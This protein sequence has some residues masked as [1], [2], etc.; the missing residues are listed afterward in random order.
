VH[1][2]VAKYDARVLEQAVHTI[3]LAGFSK[4]QPDDAP[5]MEFI[6]TYN[7]FAG[8]FGR[9]KGRAD[10]PNIRHRDLLERYDFRNLDEFDVVIVEC[11]ERGLFDEAA[12]KQQAA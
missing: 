11:I 2:I 8:L 10:D 3:A 7:S 12:I 4:F 9:H 1:D 5:P 6:R